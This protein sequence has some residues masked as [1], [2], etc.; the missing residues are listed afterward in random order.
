M[1]MMMIISN[2]NVN[3]GAVILYCTSDTFID[4][5]LITV[6]KF[7]T[8]AQMLNMTTMAFWIYARVKRPQAWHVGQSVTTFGTLNLVPQAPD[9]EGDDI[10]GANV[11]IDGLNDCGS[12][13][14]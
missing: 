8:I 10:T 7:W 3:D 14:V 4:E 5:N 1:A 11:D 6:Y 12:I 2:A 13:E 9:V